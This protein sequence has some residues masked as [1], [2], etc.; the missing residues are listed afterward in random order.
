MFIRE[1]LVKV[2]KKHR[3]RACNDPIVKGETCYSYTGV[4]DDGFYTGHFHC[5][6]RKATSHWD[7]DDWECYFPGNLIREE[8]LNG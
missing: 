5:D 1:K 4:G 3:C 8:I 2:R 6:C 7:N